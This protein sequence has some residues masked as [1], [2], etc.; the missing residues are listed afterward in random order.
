MQIGADLVRSYS[1][2]TSLPSICPDADR[3]SPAHGGGSECHSYCHV[4]ESAVDLPRCRSAQSCT[5]HSYPSLEQRA[6]PSRLPYLAILEE[7]YKTSVDNPAQMA[8]P[9]VPQQPPDEASG[10]LHLRES[11]TTPYLIPASEPRLTEL[12]ATEDRMNA[13]FCFLIVM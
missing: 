6:Y 12:P 11:N 2:C 7:M 1:M 8:Q 5:W 3:R 13:L 4:H 10:V 9:S